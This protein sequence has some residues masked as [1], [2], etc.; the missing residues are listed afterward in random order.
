MGQLALG[1]RSLFVRAS[2]F[3][4]LAALLAWSLGGTLW[5]RPVSIDYRSVEHDG[6]EWNLRL[7]LEGRHPVE[8][9][10]FLMKRSEG[11]RRV[12][13]GPWFDAAGPVVGADGLF[14]AARESDGSGWT[15]LR[16]LHDDVKA[17]EALP[18]RLAVERRFA[19][20][21][22]SAAPPRSSADAER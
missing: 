11:D 14:I 12:V 8:P 16:V 6:R 17:E 7:S 10:W 21:T 18:D 19:D 9:H 15:L 22:D 5:P 4:V 20:L 13:A 1:L 2:I 3:F